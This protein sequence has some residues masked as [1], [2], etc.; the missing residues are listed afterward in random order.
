[1]SRMRSTRP[2][3][4][5]TSWTHSRTASSTMGNDRVLAGHLE[6]LR[7]PLA[8]LPQRLAAVGPATG[9]Q[10]GAGR[11]L[12][13]SGREQG[14]PADLLGDQARARRRGRGSRGRGARGR[15]RGRAR[16]R[17]SSS[18]RSGRRSTMPS[19]PCMACTST[20][21]RS[22]IRALTASAQGACTCAPK[23]EWIATRQSPS[24]SRKRST[25][26]VRSSGTWPVASRCSRR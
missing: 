24:S 1:M 22:R 26:I 18:S 10:Q 21:N 8:L 23:G 9:E 15:P 13:E 3:T 6:Q 19:S 17:A 2:G 11:A 25:T 20:P 12:A 4:S 5:K 7:G 16:R 14:G